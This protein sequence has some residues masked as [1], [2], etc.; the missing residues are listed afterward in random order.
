MI[1][2][3]HFALGAVALAALLIAYAVYAAYD[4]RRQER[5]LLQLVADSTSQMRDAL[6]RPPAPG[7]LERVDANLQAVKAPRVPEL[8]AAAEQYLHTVREI[9]RR[10]VASEKLA[11]EAA[12]SRQAMAGHLARASSRNSA[13]IHQATELR[14]ALDR[15]H[16]D[17]G[18]SLKALDELLRDV[19][20]VTR[21]LPPDAVIDSATVEQA[22][23]RAQEDARRAA[24]EHARARQLPGS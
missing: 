13:W 16:F 14:K 7:E 11:Q 21:G 8:A 23:A 6:A 1:S 2:R 20:Q 12:Q 18:L 10:R 24:A 3:R 17:L 4:K 19:P 5:M 15:A 9:V 22:R